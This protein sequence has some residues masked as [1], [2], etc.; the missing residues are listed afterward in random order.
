MKTYFGISRDHSGSMR[1]I[2]PA[3]A[4]DY[5]SLIESLKTESRNSNQDTIVSV[6]KCGTTRAAL[7][8]RE[9]VNSNVSAL[10]AL[11]RHEYDTDGSST[12]LFDSVGELI[13]ILSSVPDAND[14]TVAFV[15]MVITDG[16][17]NSSREWR[18]KLIPK[19]QELQRT[20]RWTFIFRV[21]RG[22]GRELIGFGI[23]AGNILEWD[24]TDR[25]VE[26]ASQAT[27]QAM[28]QFYQTRA[29]G[30]T[31]TQ[32]FYADLSQ[33]SESTIKQELVD[34]SSEVQLWPVSEKDNGA[35]LRTFVESRLKGP[36]LKGASFYQLTKT[37]P[38][39]QSYKKI[40]IRDKN[41]NAIYSGIHARDLLGL[42]HHTD[43]RL[44]PDK[45]G[46][47]DIFIQ[48][49]SVNRKLAKNTQLLYWAN[50]GKN[51]TEGPSA[52]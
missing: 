26:L 7:V 44:A 35:E 51:F 6:V 10:K 24:Q 29:M 19:I 15:I 12:P 16:G 5:N 36:M 38:K 33:V 31:S 22:Y 41:T 14:P 21:P 27:A 48:S 1:S 30:Q 18:N 13:N 32:K 46:K 47:Y 20:D 25:G 28:T 42:P 37:E 2:G 3:A 17:E 23:P 8:T 4:K 34:I 45:S 52:K 40:A 9:I 43:V 49:T 11:T 39:V 50:V